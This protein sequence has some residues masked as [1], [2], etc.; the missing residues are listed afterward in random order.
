MS[1]KDKTEQVLRDIYILLSK[2]EIYNGDANR[3]IVDKEQIVELLNGLSVCVSG[4][5]DEYGI[6]QSGRDRLER[7]TKKAKDDI[8]RSANRQ[9]EDIYAAAFLYTDEALRRVLEVMQETQQSVKALCKKVELDFQKEQESVKNNK[10]EL[11]GQLRVF[12]DTDKYLKLIEEQNKALEREQK[13]AKMQEEGSKYAKIK[14]EIKVNAAY[15]ERMGIPLEDAKDGEAKE[16]AAGF[17][18]AADVPQDA[19]NEEQFSD[20]SKETVVPEI[21]VNLDAEYFKWRDNGLKIEEETPLDEKEA[22]AEV[23]RKPEKRFL[24]GKKRTNKPDQSDGER[25]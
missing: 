15:F 24:F 19:E 17:R 13:K 2:S 12:R 22:D 11:R 7:E 10:M 5:M 25:S 14:P 20:E 6:S 23:D 21:R 18:S 9:V 4:L 16:S 3:L 8:V 1:I